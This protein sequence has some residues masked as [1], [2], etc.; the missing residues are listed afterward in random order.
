MSGNKV[1][2]IEAIGEILALLD[3]PSSKPF[4]CVG[5][6]NHTDWSWISSDRISRNPT[7]EISNISKNVTIP[8]VEQDQTKQNEMSESRSKGNEKSL[9]VTG[10]QI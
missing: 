8:R 10:M 6:I 4:K 3:K 7:Y 1:S 5:Q 9:V 2:L